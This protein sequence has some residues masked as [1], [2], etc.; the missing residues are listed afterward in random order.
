LLDV[1]LPEGAELTVDLEYWRI[2]GTPTIAGEFNLGLRYTFADQPAHV[3]HT[4]GMP[5]VINADPKTLW[6]NNPSDR[7]APFWKEDSASSVILGQQAKMIAA[8]K[9][10]VRTPIRAP[11]VTTISTCIAT[12]QTAG[13]LRS[14]PMVRAAPSSLAAAPKS[15]PGSEQL[16]ERRI[17]G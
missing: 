4:A 1:T 10:G 2:T 7:S 14:L 3:S 13:I 11:A 9:R 17:L 8:R 6:Q 16:S 5:F 15:R 12:T